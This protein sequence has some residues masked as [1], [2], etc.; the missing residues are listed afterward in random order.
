MTRL[1]AV[2]LITALSIPTFGAEPQPAKMTHIIAQYSGAPIP[3]NSFASKP[4]TIWRATD[5]FCR[6]EEEPDPQANLHLVVI[7]NEPDA[8]LVDLANNRA[9]HMVDPGPTFNCRLPVFAFG[10]A[11]ATGK[12]GELQFGRESEF[13]HTHGAKQVEGTDLPSF[14]AIYYELKIDDA[15]LKLVERE[16]THA[17]LMITLTQGED[18]TTVRYSLWE[19]LPFR[20]E[21]FAKPTGV[22]IEEKH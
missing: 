2:L 17:P 14:K 21:L 4:K 13:F 19:E 15:T 20:A 9:K 6:N 16:D 22:N 10:Q 18:V 3:T 7:T 12:I 5:S 1:F 11:M 8:W